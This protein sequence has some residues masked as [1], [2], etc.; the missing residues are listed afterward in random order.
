MSSETRRRVY[1]TKTKYDSRVIP[2]RMKVLK[3]PRL[4]ELDWEIKILLELED[5][6]FEILKAQGI[7]T[8]QWE[9][10]MAFS[11]RLW[12]RAVHFAPWIAP[13]NAQTTFQLE[14]TSLLTEFELRGLAPFTLGLIQIEAEAMAYLKVVRV[15]P[16]AWS[17]DNVIGNIWM[18]ET[19]CYDSRPPG[20]GYIAEPEG[21]SGGYYDNVLG[22]TFFQEYGAY[23][24]R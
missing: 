1:R 7:P 11:K 22:P 15:V 3:K 20:T 17:Y 5:R 16:P 18:F 21:S 19:G 24:N 2:R 8:D 12:E 10:Y 13:V 4:E 23:D 14:K 9:P 6:V